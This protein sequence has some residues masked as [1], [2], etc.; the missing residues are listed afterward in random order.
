MA[1]TDVRVPVTVTTTGAERIQRLADEVRGLAAEGGAAAP[2]FE[3]L[4]KEFDKLGQQAQGL[5][6][7][8]SLRDDIEVLGAAQREAAQATQQFTARQREL[9]A[10]V[11]QAK[12]THRDVAAAYQA[13]RRASAEASDALA[14]HRANAD[15]S[16][17][18]TAEYTTRLR[19]LV[20]DQVRARG[21]VRET[22]DALTEARNATRQAKDDLATFNR[23]NARLAGALRSANTALDQRRDVLDRSADELQR[24]GVETT[25]LAAAQGQLQASLE[26][27]YGELTK[28]QAGIV[29][30][31][32]EEQRLARI[33]ALVA[34]SNERNLALMRHVVQARE[35]AA[36]QAADA[37]V[38]A[39]ERAEASAKS[40][41]GTIAA[42]SQR[43]GDAQRKAA[44]DAALAAKE[45]ADSNAAAAR[46]FEER[47]ARA[48]VRS[49]Q[50]IEAEIRDVDAAVVRLAADTRVTGEEFRRAFASS[51]TR[52]EALRNELRG[53][54]Q[55]SDDSGRAVGFLRA[56]FAQFAA[57]YSG[58]ELGRKFFDANIE[59]ETLRRSLTAITG[60]TESAAAM[61]GFL[62]QTAN[63]SGLAVGALS[64]DFIRFQAAMS[65]SGIA[66]ETT[67][68]VFEQVANTA[69][70]LGLGTERA[71]LILTALGQI[72]NKGKVSLEELQGQLGE[73]LPGALRITA[74]GLG[75]TNARLLELIK[76][77]L[78]SQEFF[79]A[80]Q[81]GMT[82]AFGDSEKRVEGLAAA[83]ARFKNAL[84]QTAQQANDTSAFK[85]LISVLDGVASNL[86][87][88][89]Q[90]AVGV[91]KAFAAIKVVDAV[92]GFL[93]LKDAA[94]DNA[95]A[96]QRAALA[97]RANQQAVEGAS[98]ASATNAQSTR[99]ASVALGERAAAD[100]V[101]T[102]SVQQHTLALE[103]NAVAARAAATANTQ[104]ANTAPVDRSTAAV[105]RHTAALEADAG[106]ARAANIANTQ[107]GNTAP[108]DRSTA[109]V[110]RHTA[111]LD[112]DLAALERN[113]AAGARGA[114]TVAVDRSTASVKAHTVALDVDL[115]ALERNA[116][117]Q[118]ASAGATDR[119]ATS[120][121]VHTAAL[122][123][124]LA[125]LKRNAAATTAAATATKGHAAAVTGATGAFATLS[126][127]LERN[128]VAMSTTTV[129]GVRA[130]DAAIRNAQAM[131]LAEQ[132]ALKVELAAHK[133]GAAVR[134]KAV[135]LD[136]MTA[137]AARSVNTMGLAAGAI[138]KVPAAAG[139]AARGAGLL[140]TALGGIAGAARGLLAVVGGVPGAL[141]TA[142]ILKD[143]IKSG[144][145]WLIDRTSDLIGLVNGQHAADTRLN[146][147]RIYT[148]A[149]IKQG[150][151]ARE[152]EIAARDKATRQAIDAAEK[153]ATIAS[154]QVKVSEKIA[155]ARKIEADVHREIIALS[156][157]ENAARAQAALSASS[158]ANASKDVL[159]ARTREVEK[160]RE[161][162]A[163]IEAQKA[164]HGGLTKAQEEE[165][166]AHEATLRVLEGASGTRRDQVAGIERQI[167]LT[168]NEIA[169]IE[170][171]RAALGSLTPAQENE[172]RVR[173]E[174]LSVL[175]Q[176]IET[177]NRGADSIEADIAKTRNLIAALE[178][179]R[180]A[181]VGLS[182]AL[183]KDLQT[184]KE[185]LALQEAE[186]EKARQAA[187]NAEIEA[188]AL[189]IVAVTAQDNAGKVEQ[190]RKEL[191]AANDVLRVMRDL[192][193]QGLVPV[194]KLTEATQKASEAEAKYRDALKD[195]NKA[196]KDQIDLGVA[197]Q[198]IAQAGLSLQLQEARNSEAIANA[199]GDERAATEAKVRQKEI[200]IRQVQ[201]STTA[202]RQELE[203]ERALIQSQ[204]EQLRSRGELTPELQRELELRLKNI[205]AMLKE[206][207]AARARV[208][209]IDAE[210]E[211]LRRLVQQR[212]AVDLSSS[213]STRN[214]QIT[215]ESAAS[216]AARNS[217]NSAAG[218][219]LGGDPF[220]DLLAR[221][222]A[223]TLT[224]GDLSIA[225]AV[226]DNMAHNLQAMQAAPGETFSAAG[227]RETQAQYNQA[228][229]I[230]D[231]VRA[232]AGGAGGPGSSGL[233]TGAPASNAGGIRPSAGAASNTN[234]IRPGAAPT[235]APTPSTPT[236][237]LVTRFD[238]GTLTIADLAA[239]QQYAAQLAAQL[240]A[241]QSQAAQGGV[242][243]AQ[244][245][246]AQRLNQQAQQM[247][248]A[249]QALLA[250]APS[251]SP[252][253]SPSPAPTPSPA[254]APTPA[255][256]PAPTTPTPIPP[257]VANAVPER[258]VR[259]ELVVAGTTFPVTGREST[260][261]ALLGAIEQA[262]RSAG[263]V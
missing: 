216:D 202:K 122:D 106:A 170:A 38:T 138:G 9:E 34:E 8:S 92:R 150:V 254:P 236:A 93:G 168:Q 121:K 166:R 44:D 18:G 154:N 204:I 62:Q 114:N 246:E 164:A 223:G 25:D 104:G 30:T 140:G 253:P 179:Q 103:A 89:L 74:D 102:T 183:E 3:R 11:T 233:A 21:A 251:P 239:V 160:A 201:S 56:Q 4:A 228:R 243:T 77:G 148:E 261:D 50:A 188:A 33:A 58:V 212:V 95:T 1:T 61:I 80:F 63:N 198:R 263:V 225:Q 177:R 162:I 66:A 112:V 29:R 169:S 14:L 55:A 49:A 181:N 174:T 45:L 28:V 252:S 37:E 17:R 209:S 5:Q 210:I 172:L 224:A 193:E 146:Q 128:A 232:M 20:G 175:Q 191:D 109:A 249:V 142:F 85:G 185:K 213:A 99:A 219:A 222:Q 137:A 159:A 57:L 110:Q 76:S 43:A 126:G 190:W 124:D 250:P 118:G 10:V 135:A 7:I 23:E 94:R 79:Q 69:G 203:A 165:L 98:A 67:R 130:S 15:A 72:A 39:F 234:G 152:A 24:N 127:A 195:S 187:K 100:R 19:E 260:V 136:V 107:G 2:E 73:S 205:D 259:V 123:V 242:T 157:D 64:Q 133:S 108:V 97:A 12:A 101:A 145:N 230:L 139:E 245:A 156:G 255:P 22:A 129:A 158:V 184:R 241:L 117:A 258:T 192:V 134:E 248:E 52:L 26:R 90:V 71:G 16:T 218:A 147:E 144:V 189:R 91:G 176:Q 31:A 180:E 167:L 120:V 161:V 163:A 221:F 214:Q 226:F 229:A 119:T 173:R 149:I 113:A 35:Q 81:R 88:I 82:G 196:R 237:D 262:Q 70:R 51:A 186:A 125:A 238:A 46:A 105:Q 87:S 155:E 40:A 235:P 206:N 199:L 36:K 59:I 6:Q 200:E 47:F 54:A 96:Q 41:F 32:E 111:A 256:V 215:A 131:R 141:F 86:D 27:V 48:G 194:E 240:A 178:A 257:Q 217:R 151:A 84:T 68:N 231:I 207:D 60:S 75:V 53:V 132:A 227:R 153:E 83:W 116:A 211:T 171:Q 244:L 65:S 115:A 13:A 220:F 208:G 42:V 143:E 197:N 78:S 247:L 182:A